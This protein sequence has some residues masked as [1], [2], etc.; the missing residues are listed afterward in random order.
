MPNCTLY[1]KQFTA[2]VVALLSITLTATGQAQT[3]DS[4]GMKTVAVIAAS[5][6]QQLVDDIDKLGELGGQVKAG[7][8]LENMLAFFTQ[9]KGLQGL[10]KSKPWGAVVQT[11]G[12]QFVPVVCLP[13]TDL[14]ALLELA[15][16]FQMKTSD[17]G[18]GIT[19]IEIPNQSIYVKEGGGWAYLAQSAEMLADTPNDPAATFAALAADYDIGARLMVQNVPEMYR[20]IALEQIR[21]GAEQNMQQLDGESN[22]DFAMRRKAAEAQVEQIAQMMQEFDELV[23]GMNYDNAEGNLVL[24]VTSKPLPNT[25]SA[26]V[27][28]VYQSAKTAFA[29]CMDENAAVRWNVSVSSPPELT[30][31]YA[32]QSKAQMDSMRQQAMNAIDKDTEL[33]NDAARE[34]VKS[35]VNDLMDSLEATLMSGTFDVAGHMNITADSLKIVG[36]GYAKE[37]EKIE[38]AAKKIEAMLKDEPGFTGVNWNAA[39]HGGATIHTMSIPIPA[40]KP[41]AQRMLGEKLEVALALGTEVFYFSAGQNCMANLKQAMDSSGGS[42]TVTPVQMSIALQPIVKTVAEILPAGNPVVTEINEAL[43]TSEGLDEIH[44]TLEASG[45]KMRGRLE[46]ESGVLKTIGAGAR[47]ARMQ[48]AGAGF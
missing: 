35:A 39:T 42:T 6:Y 3:P 17:V 25:D 22:E 47:A 11:D 44:M 45:G 37:T 41:E 2:A 38:S 21:A 5:D 26:E 13:V 4:G 31:K 29:G 7:Q 9:G 20:N 34:T 30:A 36:G 46:L 8:Q 19:E 43:L 33:P 15:T 40:D 18:D 28:K 32:D 10:D 24:D 12:F 48:G 14:P 27:L 23:I 1:R 16:V